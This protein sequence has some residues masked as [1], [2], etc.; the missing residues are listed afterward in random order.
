MVLM[1][2]QCRFERVLVQGMRL[3]IEEARDW[4]LDLIFWCERILDPT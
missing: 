2:F 1:D 4:T 3:K